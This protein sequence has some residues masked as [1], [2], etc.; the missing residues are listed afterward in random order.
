M[1]ALAGCFRSMKSK[2][3]PGFE[4][5]DL[6]ASE[7]SFSVN[8]VD[9]LYIMFGKLSNSIIDDGLIHKEE[10]LYALFNC[11]PKQNLFA[12]RLFDLFDLKHNGVIEFGEF[13]RSLSIFHPRTPQEDKIEFAFKLYDL[14]HTGFIERDELKEMVFA[15]LNE[16]ELTL[17][18]DVI[19]AIVDKTILEA[20]K[21]GDGRIGPEEWKELVT[22]YPSIIKN[23]TLPFLKEITQMFP[24]F[25][26]TTEAQD[27]QLVFEN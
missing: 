26:L 20:D 16:S 2:H 7:T 23:M 27:S 15:I 11:S 19:E 17:S 4:K 13:V 6:L 18:D 5:H 14:K 25:V 1:H 22:R 8:E 24:S 3:P 9:A 12:Q 21:N 10:F